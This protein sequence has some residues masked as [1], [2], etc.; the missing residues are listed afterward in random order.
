MRRTERLIPEPPQSVQVLMDVRIGAARAAAL[1]AG[2]EQVDFDLPLDPEGGL[3]QVYL[4]LHGH[5]ATR[6]R[7]GRSAAP[8]AAE[9]VATEEGA[10]EIGEVPETIESLA[11]ARSAQTVVTVGVVDAALLRVAEHLVGFGGFL[12]LLLGLGIVVVD[13][14]V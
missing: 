12:E 8:G 2:V 13:I 4:H 5:V 7:A 11:A 6:G 10:E 1:P 3:V 9:Q 14:G